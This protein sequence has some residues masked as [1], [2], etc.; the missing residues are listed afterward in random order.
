MAIYWRKYRNKNTNDIHADVITN[1][2]IKQYCKMDYLTEIKFD[3]FTVDLMLISPSLNY[4]VGVEV[5]SPADTLNRLR[6]QLRGYLK[7]FHKVFV[8][9]TFKQLKGVMKVVNE[10]EFK[11]VGVL[12]YDDNEKVFY[13]QK[14]A[15]K[16]DVSGVGADWI[17]N[18]HQLKQ[19]DYLLERIWG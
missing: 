10:D 2:V 16:N 19:W 6:K 11:N 8:A 13:R 9:T 12:I 15:L 4:I 14:E 5:K 18:R 1:A 7:Y 17:S 3:G